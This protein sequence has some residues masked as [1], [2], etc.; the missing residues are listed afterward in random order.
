MTLIKELSGLKGDFLLF[1][2][3]AL[4]TL[5]PVFFFDVLPLHDLPSHV[6][7]LYIVQQGGVAD[8][9]IHNTIS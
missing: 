6:A 5:M 9:L 8:S 4:I 2:T 1:P 7:R 3:L